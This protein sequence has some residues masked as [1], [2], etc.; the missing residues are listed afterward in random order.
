MRLGALLPSRRHALAAALTAGLLFVAYPPFSLVAPAFLCLV[1]LL[2]MLEELVGTDAQA[3]RGTGSDDG[4]PVPLCPGAPGG[5]GGWGEVARLGYWFGAAASGLVF[6]WLVIALWHYTPLALAGYLAAVLVILA[7]GWLL[8]A[9]GYVC[10][11][12]AP[13]CRSGSSSRS[14]GPRS[15]GWWG[16][17]GTSSSPGSAWAPR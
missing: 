11:A 10:C 13:A 2:W 12:G 3:H 1:P 16:T 8:F 14:C 6:Y 17:R 5:E 4:A 9:L 15:N 7:P